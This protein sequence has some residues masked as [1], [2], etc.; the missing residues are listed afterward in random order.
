MAQ[1]INNNSENKV[2]VMDGRDL[3]EG[4]MVEF[5]GAICEFMGTRDAGMWIVVKAKGGD[6]VPLNVEE[7]E[8]YLTSEKKK[9]LPVWL[10]RG[11]VVYD[12]RDYTEYVIEKVGNSRVYIHRRGDLQMASVLLHFIECQKQ[13]VMDSWIKPGVNCKHER[14]E[15]VILDVEGCMAT[16]RIDYGCN[17]VCTLN[18]YAGELR[19]CYDE[20]EKGFSCEEIERRE[21]DIYYNAYGF[22]TRFCGN[23]HLSKSEERE[24]QEMW[25][26]RMIN[27]C[28]IYGTLYSFFN[29]ST[30]KFVEYG[31]EYENTLGY[32]VTLKL[33][34]AQQERFKHAKVG[35]AGTDSEGCS[36]NYCK[37]DS[38]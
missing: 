37:W 2:R 3:K 28:L 35:Y 7:N 23:K 16:V 18:V 11:M 8:V 22:G 21:R 10:R 31:L 19:P 20:H 30:Q 38:A 29:E 34:R 4:Q 36:Y 17:T 15:A 26:R 1:N 13:P 33:L 9:R 25:C 6:R 24:M 12:T 5:N 14:R 27:S 32:D